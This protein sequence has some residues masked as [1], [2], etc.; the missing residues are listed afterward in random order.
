MSLMMSGNFN[1][2][3]RSK[4]I[5][6]G[7]IRVQDGSNDMVVEYVSSIAAAAILI[8]LSPTNAFD[9]ATDNEIK[10][11]HIYELLAYQIVPE[12]FMDFYVTFMEVINGLAKLH[13]EYW[14][15]GKGSM[16]NARYVGDRLS[17]HQKAII[18][19]FCSTIFL[20]GCVLAA[21]VK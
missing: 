8:F 15:M 6:Q 17:E 7:R 16:K 18:V 2:S 12:I 11:H 5:S 21:V 1:A 9:L 10:T 14:S 20:T 13:L 4:F 3:E 19:K